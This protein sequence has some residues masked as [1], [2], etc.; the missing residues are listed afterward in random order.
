MAAFRGFRK[1]GHCS[2]VAFRFHLRIPGWCWARE[3]EVDDETVSPGGA[4][5]VSLKVVRKW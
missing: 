1:H 2:K 4:N 5:G 3:S